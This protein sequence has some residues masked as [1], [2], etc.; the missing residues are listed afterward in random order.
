M[1]SD[2]EDNTSTTNIL[3][4]G[5]SSLTN[6]AQINTAVSNSSDLSSK[7]LA[8]RHLYYTIHFPLPQD[9]NTN[10]DSNQRHVLLYGCGK[11]RDEARHQIK[12]VLKEVLKLFNRKFSMDISEGKF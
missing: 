9:E 10:N 3:S 4:A 12:K 2:K 11:Q 8:Q 1:N 5:L 6:S 7:S